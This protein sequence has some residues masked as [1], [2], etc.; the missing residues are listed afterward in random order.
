MAQIR[1]DRFGNA[2]MLKLAKPVTNRKTGEVMPIWKTYFQDGSKL[3][4]V[5]ISESKKAD[6][7][8]MWVKFTK[9]NQQRRN[10]GFG[11]NSGG[12]GNTQGGF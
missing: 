4:K 8:G 11:N 3:I 9:V 12:Y 7:E 10:T 1:Q 2:S 6:R 5:E